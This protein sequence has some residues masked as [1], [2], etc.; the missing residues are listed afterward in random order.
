MKNFI[1]YIILNLF[2]STSIFPQTAE[3]EQLYEKDGELLYDKSTQQPFTGILIERNEQ[4]KIIAK[5][6][7]V[8]GLENGTS[9]FFDKNGKLVSTGE[10]KNGLEDGQWIW[11]YT[12]D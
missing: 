3:I 6:S 9:R 7:F 11:F 8:N 12:S 4:G 2:F 5:K 1:S 10:F